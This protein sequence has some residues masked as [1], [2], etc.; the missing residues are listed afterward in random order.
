MCLIFSEFNAA[1]GSRNCI[2]V[3]DRA[4]AVDDSVAVLLRLWFCPKSVTVF[5]RL[6]SHDWVM[7]AI[8]DRWTVA[9]CSVAKDNFIPTDGQAQNRD[10]KQRKTHQKSHATPEATLPLL[11]SVA[12]L[13]DWCSHGNNPAKMF[14][15]PH[16]QQLYIINHGQ[17]QLILMG[18]RRAR[19]GKA[20]A[21]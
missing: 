10:S 7:A 19:T 11:C 1:G 3:G 6:C 2:M 21:T 15:H 12:L 13:P 17:W 5:R 8:F 4:V 20:W 14:P 16:L 9:V 18:G